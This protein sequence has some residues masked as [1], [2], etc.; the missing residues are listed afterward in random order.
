MGAIM[1]DEFTLSR[2]QV[3]EPRLAIDNTGGGN[4]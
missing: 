4:A 2:H 3:P 1:S